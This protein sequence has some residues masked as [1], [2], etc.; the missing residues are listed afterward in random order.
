MDGDEHHTGSRIT[1][2]FRLR[3]WWLRIFRGYHL[4]SKRRMPKQN[5]FGEIYYKN[6]WV[7]SRRDEK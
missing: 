6:H 4:N 2:A 1:T 5:F 3:M 7:L